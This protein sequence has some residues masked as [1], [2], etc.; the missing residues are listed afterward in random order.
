MIEGL[1]RTQVVSHYGLIQDGQEI[2]NSSF[3]EFES[4]HVTN[5]APGFTPQQILSIAEGYTVYAVACFCSFLKRKL[6]QF[7]DD[8]STGTKHPQPMLQIWPV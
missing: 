7:Q 1:D 4:S 6:V 8:F 5:I 2:W 3:G